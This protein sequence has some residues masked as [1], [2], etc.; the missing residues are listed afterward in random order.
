[1]SGWDLLFRCALGLAVGL[2]LGLVGWVI[3]QRSAA[4]TWSIRKDEWTCVQTRHVR[5]LQP[6]LVGKVTILV[7]VT[8]EECSSYLR[9]GSTT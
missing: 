4:P 1:M 7:P 5:V 8:R 6:R 2:I 9:N 3:Y